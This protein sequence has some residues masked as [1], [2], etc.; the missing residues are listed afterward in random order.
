VRDKKLIA[1]WFFVFL[2]MCLGF[3]NQSIAT[4]IPA[5]ANEWTWPLDGDFM[6]LRNAKYNTT[7]ENT[8]YAVKNPDLVHDGAIIGDDHI[9]CSDVGWHR[10]YNAG[11][12]LYMRDGNTAG[13]QVTAISDGIVKYVDFG[14][15]NLSVISRGCA[16]RSGCRRRPSPRRPSRRRR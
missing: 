12:D 10:S 16:P 5:S 6:V 11:V 13:T 4:D 9:T 3:V 7:I 1:L 15:D 14:K 2:V 8:D